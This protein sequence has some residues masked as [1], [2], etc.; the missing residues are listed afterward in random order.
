MSEKN[1]RTAVAYYEAMN[2][3]DLSLMEK[4]LHAEVRFIGPL[5]DL[6]GRDAVL[7]AVKHLLDAFNK[8]KIRAQF[9]SGE[10]VMLAYDIDFPP[11]IGLSRAAVLLTFQDGLIIRYELF[12]DARPFEKR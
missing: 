8:L 4:Y 3:K 2:K 6:K 11:P 9:G 1:I 7:G 12:F 10:E 5:G